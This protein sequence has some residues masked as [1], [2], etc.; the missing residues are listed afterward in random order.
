MSFGVA[1]EVKK[2]YKC[3]YYSLFIVFKNFKKGIFYTKE[4]AFFNFRTIYA[5]FKIDGGIS[6]Q[7]N[8]TLFL[9]TFIFFSLFLSLIV[10][11]IL[12]AV[13]FAC[14]LYINDKDNTIYDK[15]KTDNNYIIQSLS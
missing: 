3:L 10:F 5:P 15:L 14:G 1:Y 8:R 2:S 9:N 7:Y 6:E 12:Q 13:K 11:F 4:G